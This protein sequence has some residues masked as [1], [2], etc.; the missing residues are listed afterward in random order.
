MK[1]I[2]V[3]KGHVFAAE[4]PEPEVQKGNVKIKVLYSCISAG[5]ELSN[6]SSTGK[7]IIKRVAEKPEIISRGLEKI[8]KMGIKSYWESVQTELQQALPSGY[9]LAGRIIETGKDVKGFKVGDLVAAAG[10][11]VAAHSEIAVVP[12]NLVVAIPNELGVK[13]ASTVAIGGIALQGIRRANLSFGSNVAV[14]GTGLLGLLTIQLLKA[15][16][17][18][19]LAIDLDSKRLEIAKAS[20]ADITKIASDPTLFSDAIAWADGHGVDATI[21][22]ASTNSEEPLSQAF[23]ICRKKGAVVLVGVTGMK[24]NRKDIY[25]KELDFFISTS[26]GPGRYDDSYEKE[27]LDYPY[28]YVRWTENRNMQAYL[29]AL[30]NGSLNLNLLSQEEYTLSE[31]VQAFNALKQTEAPL[32]SYFKY[33]DQD[34]QK[35]TSEKINTP[36]FKGLNKNQLLKTALIGTGSFATNMTLPILQSLRKDF[37]LEVLVNQTPFKAQNIADKFNVPNIAASVDDLLSNHDV[38]VVFITTKHAT[39]SELVLKCLKAG[40]HVFVEKP[41]AVNEEQLATIEDF[42]KA[43]EDPKP[44]LTVGFNRRF[45]PYALEIKK[46]VSSRINPLIATYRMNAGFQP[47]EHWTHKDGGRIIGEGCHI[48][49]LFSFL[50]DDSPKSISVDSISGNKNGITDSD[51]RIITISYADGSICTLL[52]TGQGSN[53]LSKE[54]LELFY[55]QK[56]I[57]MDDYKQL[58]GHGVQLNSNIGSG[59]KGHKAIIKTFAAS[60]KNNSS[61]PISFESLL[62]STE[63]SFIASK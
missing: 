44:V 52:Y 18:N 25:A 38:D 31:A 39:H 27:G 12:V 29:K 16:G 22:T 19:V 55:D 61:W 41:L 54:K 28:G 57:I 58:S 1:Q 51:N 7:S 59:D 33:K 2:L 50:V 46:Q 35:T 42:Y 5:T 30:A 3:K 10:G 21:I 48:I 4:L 62:N 9:S 63:L 37:K 6:I 53:L 34:P 15:N 45:S 40:K 23:Q 47:L 43:N 11:I 36:P 17:M 14:L 26:Y 13:E 32:L 20:G 49:D 56:S 8:S 60:I 24:I